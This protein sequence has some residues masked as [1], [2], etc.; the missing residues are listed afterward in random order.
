MATATVLLLAQPVLGSMA[1]WYTW[2]TYELTPH[3]ALQDSSSGDILHSA[4]NSNGSA[5]FPTDEPHRFH[6]DVPARSATPLQVRGWWDEDLNTPVAYL[7]YQADDTKIMNALFICNLTTGNYFADPNEVYS[8]SDD[9]GAPSVHE[10]SGLAVEDLGDAGGFRVFYHDED[11]R[12]NMVAWDE[13][14]DW[15]YLGPVSRKSV[16][17]R[18]IGS[19]LADDRAVS[20]AFPHDNGNI[21]VAQFNETAEDQWSLVSVPRPFARPVPT[22]ETNAS[23]MTLVRADDAPFSLIGFSA[24][25]TEVHL[26]ANIHNYRRIFYLGTD[27][28]MHQLY[29]VDG[30]RGGW[31]IAGDPEDGEWPVADNVSASMALISEPETGVI[32]VY[33]HSGGEIMEM[34]QNGFNIW[35]EPRIAL[36]S[37]GTANED[38]SNVDEGNG[39]SGNSNDNTSDGGLSTGAQAGIGVGV[40]LAVLGV[41]AAVFFFIRRR[42]LAA[43]AEEEA[44]AAAG[45]SPDGENKPPVYSG[46]PTTHSQSWHQPGYGDDAHKS[47][48]TAEPAELTST[49][50][51]QELPTS[52][53]YELPGDYH[54]QELGT[55][56]EIG[57]AAVRES[58]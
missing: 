5:V 8:V 43:S 29:E 16:T 2:T 45:G 41:A 22:N 14:T 19:A 20:V 6:L 53:R 44:A 46:V 7:F 54:H 58:R 13:D 35:R 12:V 10:T 26:A 39:D 34:Y 52:V 36:K 28:R 51:P 17:G 47:P 33:Y 25:N 56:G 50:A 23:N 38:D 42:K 15:I 18:S 31:D 21:A 49:T 27:R 1:G 48:A 40:G 3:F 11:E 4:C 30:G 24:S 37:N 55:D 57:A 9:A 32:W